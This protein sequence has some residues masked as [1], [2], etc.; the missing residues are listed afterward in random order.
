MTTKRNKNYNSLIMQAFGEKPV[1]F[2]PMLAEVARCPMAGLFLSQLLFWWGKG[3]RREGMIFKTIKEMQS[4]THLSR[5][6]QSRAIA[7]WK[8]L[9]VVEV[10]YHDVPRRRY[11][12]INEDRLIELLERISGRGY[13]AENDSGTC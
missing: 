2:N 4:E 11:F 6:R 13:G 12:R 9:G 3:S 10:E 5:S 7:I 8:K 1:A